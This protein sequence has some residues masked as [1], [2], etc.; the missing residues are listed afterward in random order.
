MPLKSKNQNFTENGMR[1]VLETR[2]ESEYFTR[3]GLR[4]LTGLPEPKWIFAIF[5]ELMDNALDAV[6]EVD[7][8]RIDLIKDRD[9]GLLTIFDSGGG[10]P[11]KILDSIYDFSV[12]VSSKRDFRTPTRGSQ[13]NA[14]KTVI[15]IC[16]LKDLDLGFITQGKKISYEVNRPKLEA[17]IVEF[18]K[19]IEKDDSGKAGG[20]RVTGFEKV[21]EEKIFEEVFSYYLCN[22]DV[23]FTVNEKRLESVTPP[24][25]RTEKT[26]IHWYDLIGFNQLLQ[27][28]H[29]KD[30]LRTTKDFCLKFSGTQRILSSLDFRH[31]RLS[32]FS[33]DQTAI[34]D[35]YSELKEKTK[36]P[37]AR[38]LSNLITTKEALLKIYGDQG[39]YKYKCVYG[40]SENGGASIPYV[41]EEF[42][43]S[44]ENEH[45]PAKIMTAINNSVPYEDVPFVFDNTQC[46]EFCGGEYWAN[47]LK[48]LLDK[49]GFTKATGV[50]L[51]INFIAPYI[52]FTDKAKTSVI[53]R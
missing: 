14:L 49:S 45:A 46:H 23:T 39:K 30:P 24:I 6:N 8:K 13:G 41:I 25:K 38:I 52:E 26:F 7:N 43:L 12:Y 15:A 31:K 48:S 19:T 3:E 2:R 4:T 51:Y 28:V 40:E 21:E 47:N 35:L 42:L 11:E 22:P 17:G 27:K 44:N 37:N 16:H 18:S 53:T 20:V 50:I 5:K 10:I 36:K 1:E 32:D 9:N 29:N 33:H 34:E